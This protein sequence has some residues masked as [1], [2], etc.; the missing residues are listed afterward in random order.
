MALTYSFNLADGFGVKRRAISF[1]ESVTDGDLD[2]GQTFRNLEGN[3]RQYVRTSFDW[4]IDGQHCEK[5][6]HGWPNDH[7]HRN[8]FTFKW[9]HKRQHHRQHHRLYGFLCNPKPSTDAGFRLCVLAFHDRKNE[10]ETNATILDRCCALRESIEVIESIA[11]VYPEYR[12][13]HKWKQ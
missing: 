13:T 4:W 6:F 11:T 9:T 2:A 7:D 3:Q 12:G 5:R 8:C 10:W 1:L